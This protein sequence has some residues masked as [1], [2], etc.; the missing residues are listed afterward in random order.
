M[1][2]EE[3]MMIKA[4]WYY[5]L[6]D[7]TQQQIAELLGVTRVRVIK[8]LE[9]ARNTGIIQFKIRSDS[10]ERMEHEKAL[11]SKF[12]LNDAFVVPSNPNK[13]E[14]NE[15]IAKAGAM[16]LAERLQENEFINLGYGDTQS[17]LLNHL[18]TIT[19]HPI[20]C[21]SLTGGVSYY[22]PNARSN[23]FNAKLYLNPSPLVASSKEM[24]QAMRKESSV[25][26]ISRMVKLSKYT[27]VGIGGL[28]DSATVLQSGILTK[29]DFV[30]L[31]MQG[32]QGDILCHFIDKNGTLVNTPIEDRLI[33]TS[34]DTLK[35]L[36]NVIAAAAGEE[37]IDAIRAALTGG[38]LNVLITDE[39]TAAALVTE[40]S[41]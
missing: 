27:I 40:P 2:F 13:A 3:L 11:V 39:E 21:V 19:N 16:Y 7:M 36:D 33:S 24:A 32:V 38:Y 28:G 12:G 18:A 10:A 1:D 9:K 25:K 15:T 37:K 23:I 22:L 35:E 20:N 30:Y 34:L 26:Q 5:Y 6:E 4:A 8:M 17:R 29:S 31:K 14:T 41:N